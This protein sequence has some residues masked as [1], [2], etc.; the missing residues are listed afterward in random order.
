MNLII[1]PQ[2]WLIYCCLGYCIRLYLCLYSLCKLFF[3][4]LS[5]DIYF[6]LPLFFLLTHRSFIATPF[7]NAALWSHSAAWWPTHVL[8]THLPHLYCLSTPNSIH[9]WHVPLF[10]QRSVQASSLLWTRL[11]LLLAPPAGFNLL[12]P[13]TPW[14]SLSE[15]LTGSFNIFYVL[16]SV[17]D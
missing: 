8:L 16:V 3:T 11:S 1:F 14:W 12:C 2:T 10:P 13:P 6:S 4:L 5:K 7:G 17:L 15:L 9:L